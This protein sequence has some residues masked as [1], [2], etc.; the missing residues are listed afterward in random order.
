MASDN[1]GKE[2]KL[3]WYDKELDLS[4]LPKGRYAIYITN[5]SN[6]YDYGELSDVLFADLSKASGKFNDKTYKFYL[7]EDLR[8]R[9][10][11]EI[12]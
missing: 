8:N 5:R 6:I 2:K 7:N 11:L 3:A 10:E 1:F 9:I 12:K 4:D